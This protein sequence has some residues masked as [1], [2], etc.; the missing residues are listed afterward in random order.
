MP[1]RAND[2]VQRLLLLRNGN[3]NTKL[4]GRFDQTFDASPRFKAMGNK[5][6]LQ[7]DWTPLVRRLSIDQLQRNG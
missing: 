2:I 4:Y 7:V 6:N 3:L 5:L 1:H